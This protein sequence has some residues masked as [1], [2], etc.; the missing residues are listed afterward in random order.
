MRKTY[1]SILMACLLSMTGMAQEQLNK[2]IT[3]DKDFV[4]VEK[5]AV[6]KSALPKVMKPAKTQSPTQLNYSKWAEPT[7][8]STD[9][10][11]MLPYGYR[12]SHIFSKQRGYL[13]LGAGM[14][15]N[16][17]GSAGYR[18]VDEPDLK[19]SGWFQHNSTWSGHNSTLLEPAVSPNGSTEPLKHK[20]NDNVLGIDMEN[21]LGKGR[22]NMGLNFHIDNFNYYG[23]TGTW[24]NADNQTLIDVLLKGAWK[25]SA[26][27]ADHQ[28]DYCVSL[29][30]NYAGYNKSYVDGFNGAKEHYFNFGLNGSYAASE[31]SRLGADV[32]VDYL[33]RSASRKTGEGVTDD[34]TMITVSP[35]YALVGE[36]FNAHLG[37][38]V[39][40]S[41][42]DGAALRLSPNVRL[43]Y[44][45]LSGLTL[46]ANA[47]G[48]KHLAT[49][50]QMAAMSR[51]S[52][53]MAGYENSFTPFDTEFGFKVGPFSGFK[54]KA[55]GGYGM[56]KHQ[57][58]AYMPA[59]DYF[60]FD[61]RIL[62]GIDDGSLLYN[63]VFYKGFSTQGV[64]VGAELNYK[65]RSLAEFTAGGVYAPQ[66]DDIASGKTYSG[67]MLGL[68]RPKY[69]LNADLK[70]YPIRQLMVNLGFEFRGKRRALKENVIGSTTTADGVTT[71]LY[72]YSW[73]DMNNVCNLK[74]GARYRFDKML[75]LWVQAH[76]LL[77]KQWDTLYGMGAQK[78]GLMGG[79]S[80]V[81]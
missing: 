46:Y 17:V 70:V 11:T 76:N 66:N 8:V 60:T 25:G 52:D 32:M 3:L 79:I 34:M 18:F 30:Y 69:V 50:A 63:P 67:Y 27:V 37:A 35:F 20:F 49:M 48:G 36:K 62:V 4:P 47:T 77:N 19:V 29:K 39:N 65:Y 44:D 56:F 22:L 13:D 58:F 72:D 40:F 21:D 31:Y 53:P 10:P 43:A 57:M 15:L 78:L 16:M 42:N 2:E 45:A 59:R 41:F 55:F 24:W 81:F 5:K 71:Y 7:A 51:Y 23:M 28:V 33:G 61:G 73:I 38:N 12:T 74:A 75:T 54:F 26:L 1:I 68:D 80:L 14:Q 6:K 9:I 64:K